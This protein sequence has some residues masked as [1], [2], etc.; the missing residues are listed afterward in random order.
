MDSAITL[1][2]TI[3]G[4]TPSKDDVVVGTITSLAVKP[5]EA[6]VYGTIGSTSVQW[7]SKPDR[8]IDYINV[9][10]YPEAKYGLGE[11]PLQAQ[12]R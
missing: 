7:D 1:T 5:A 3:V 9:R 6:M 10:D 2:R 12:V 8:N 11:I 4:D